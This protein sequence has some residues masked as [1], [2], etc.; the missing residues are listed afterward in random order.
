MRKSVWKI[1]VLLTAFMLLAAA[2]AMACGGHRLKGNYEGVTVG[3]NPDP[4][5]VGERCPEGFE[6]I[7]SSAGTME[8]KTRVFKGDMAVAS[9]HCS[10]WLTPPEG[11]AWGQIGGGL[12]ILSAGEDE[13]H[14]AYEGYFRFKGD[15]TTEWVSKVAVH[16]RVVGGE[17]AFE[18]AHG[19]G[20]MFLKDETN[21]QSGRIKGL[22]RFDR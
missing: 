5:A 15:V 6:W 12:M 4:D 9:E 18:D 2:P 1:A 17:G 19:R 7:L 20:L 22:L 10:R 11:K 3:F 13:L 21:L 8:V 16:F 14:L